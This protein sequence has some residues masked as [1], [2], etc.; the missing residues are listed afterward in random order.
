MRIFEMNNVKKL[1][2]RQSMGKS[3]VYVRCTEK[4]QQEVIWWQVFRH[5]GHV[6]SVWAGGDC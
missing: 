4:S 6:K 1:L 5:Q 2:Q 3:Y